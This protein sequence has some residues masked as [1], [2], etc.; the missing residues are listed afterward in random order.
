MGYGGRKGGLKSA[1]KRLSQATA[2]ASSGSD[3]GE[4]LSDVIKGTK[5]PVFM[6]AW[7][8]T[9]GPSWHLFFY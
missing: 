8:S 1:P 2:S 9:R 6:A 4:A 3:R 5:F 7:M